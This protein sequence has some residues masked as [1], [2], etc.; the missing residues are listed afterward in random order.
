MKIK[1]EFDTDNS[2]FKEGFYRQV[3]EILNNVE[4]VIESNGI[5]IEIDSPIYDINGN[6]VGKITKEVV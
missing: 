3:K 1:I 6:K 2:S 4:N 5:L